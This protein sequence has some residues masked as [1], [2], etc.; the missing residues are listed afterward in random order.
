MDRDR[1][2]EARWCPSLSIPDCSLLPALPA[3]CQAP[4]KNSLRGWLTVNDLDPGDTL[5]P[6][7]FR[8]RPRHLPGGQR[9]ILTASVRRHGPIQNPR[10]KIKHFSHFAEHQT[11]SNVLAKPL[12]LAQG[13]KFDPLEYLDDP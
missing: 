10:T 7:R 11:C 13:A 6:I 3:K 2:C 1:L 4:T 9:G 8:S 5:G 12:R